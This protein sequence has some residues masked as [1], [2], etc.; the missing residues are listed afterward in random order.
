MSFDFNQDHYALFGLPRGYGVDLAELDRRYRELQGRVHPDKHAHL[1][2]REQRLAMQWATRANEA[3]QTLKQPIS[4]ARYL[5]ELAGVDP[6]I[7]Q[8]TAM[9]EA[10]LLQQMEW[11]EATEDAREAAD[12]RKLDQL[13]QRLRRDMTAQYAELARAFDVA[14]DYQQAAEM[15]RQLLFQEKLL[16]EI[17][18]G[19][20]A[21]EA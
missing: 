17:D 19:I 18:A 16:S 11:R 10:F 2:E 4:R 12:S 3:Y 1:G 8:N 15:V 21:L 20:E 7:E 9:P 14:N 13:H 6:Q 5:L